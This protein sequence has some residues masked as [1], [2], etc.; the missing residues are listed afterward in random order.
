MSVEQ[1]KALMRR[2]YDEVVNR[3]NLNMIDEL[4][5]PDFVD[6]EAFPGLP[7]GREGVKQFFSMLRAAFP[8]L[9]MNVDDLIAEGDKAVARGTMTGTHQG[10]F[11]GIAATGK[12]VSVPTID[13]ARFAHGK[14]AE[15]WGVTDTMS[16]AEQLGALPAT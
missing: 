12:T 2:F 13:I 4:V 14:L 8:D 3:G 7:A 6:H 1:N 15:H 11:A 10:E 9:R 16:M 5:S